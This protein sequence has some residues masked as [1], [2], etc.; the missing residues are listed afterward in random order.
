MFEEKFRLSNAN[1]QPLQGWRSIKLTSLIAFND[2]DIL[3]PE[4]V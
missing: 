2:N 4:N 3:S 1:S